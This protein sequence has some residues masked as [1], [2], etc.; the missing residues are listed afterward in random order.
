MTPATDFT[1][2]TLGKV[3]PLNPG[4]GPCGQTSAH[5]GTVFWFP[6][7]QDAR[8]FAFNPG[9]VVPP[10]TSL[11]VGFSGTGTLTAR[12]YGYVTTNSAIVSPYLG[13]LEHRS[14]DSFRTLLNR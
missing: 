12:A 7:A 11:C 1:G 14:V 2:F 9:F 10:N 5:A 6:N 4:N 13:R 3:D 8:Q